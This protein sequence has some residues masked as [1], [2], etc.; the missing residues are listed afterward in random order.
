MTPPKDC[1]RSIRGGDWLARSV[2]SIP[3]WR[4]ED[5]LCCLPGHSTSWRQ[6]R[7]EGSV[8]TTLQRLDHILALQVHGP[9]QVEEGYQGGQDDGQGEEP[10]DRFSSGY[11]KIL[12]KKSIFFGINSFETMLNFHHMNKSSQK[13]H[14]IFVVHFCFWFSNIWEEN[15]IFVSWCLNWFDEVKCD[16]VLL[17]HNASFWA[18]KL[19]YFV[20]FWIRIKIKSIVS[21]AGEPRHEDNQQRGKQLALLSLR[22]V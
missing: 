14:N 4:M 7:W 13:H 6:S 21:V 3:G 1:W 17:A 5:I 11:M 22:G 18:Q 19:I 15:N 8:I 20:F 12:L 9:V 2:W 16:I 10:A